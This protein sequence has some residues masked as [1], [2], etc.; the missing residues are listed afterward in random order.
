MRPI[1]N[2]ECLSCWFQVHPKTRD[3]AKIAE[4]WILVWETSFEQTGVCVCVQ[5]V[6]LRNEN[7]KTFYV[8]ISGTSRSKGSIT[9]QDPV[10]APKDSFIWFCLKIGTYTPIY[11]NFS[12]GNGDRPCKTINFWGTLC[13][14][15]PISSHISNLKI[16]KA[17]SSQ[18]SEN[19]C[20]RML[21]WYCCYTYIVIYIWYLFMNYVNSSLYRHGFFTATSPCPP[22][23]VNEVNGCH[24]READLLKEPPS[25]LVCRIVLASQTLPNKEDVTLRVC[26]IATESWGVSIKSYFDGTFVP[27]KW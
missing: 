22:N 14:D 10:V 6:S 15:R 5:L 27:P 7:L 24:T 12:R 13:W 11:G 21:I 23:E 3:T 19:C 16:L 18:D 26:W 2:L 25:E 9:R 17:R 4:K 8:K 1:R 20:S